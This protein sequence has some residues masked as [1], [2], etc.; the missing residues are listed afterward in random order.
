M[1][2]QVDH[3]ERRETIARALWRVVERRGAVHL[4]MRE[5]AQEAGLSHG[6][7]QHYFTSREAMLTFAMDFAAEQTALR[8]GRGVQELGDR[9]HPRDVLRLML[10]ETLPLHA[11]ARATSRMSAAYVLEALHDKNVH[12]RAREGMRQGRA[13]VEQLVR[14][15]IAD[16]Y[17]DPERDPAVETDL[18]LALTG[19]TPLIELDVIR[20][21]DALAAVDQ[22]LDRLFDKE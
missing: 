4:T 5:V 7:V 17:V 12:A 15:A 6:A 20:P 14:Q 8:V 9:P 10:M 1:P 13:L 16:G 2:K 19:F 3:Q 18:L 11:D 21:Q 22:Y